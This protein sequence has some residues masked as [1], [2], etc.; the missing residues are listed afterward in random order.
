M[1]DARIYEAGLAGRSSRSPDPWIRA[2]LAYA[3]GRLRDPEANIYFPVLLRDEDPAVR[4]AAAFG[5]GVSGDARLVRLLVPVLSDLDSKTADAAA[6]SLG[7]LGGEEATRALLG[8]AGSSLASGPRVAA[9][10]A[11]WRGSSL[12]PA[13]VVPLLGP[14]AGREPADSNGRR[15]RWEAVYALARKPVPEAAPYLRAAL[16]SADVSLVATAAR[17]LGILQ[18]VDAADHLAGLAMGPDSSV[19]IQ[20]LGALE[21]IAAKSQ[22]PPAARAAARARVMDGRP[23]VRVAALRLLGR[24]PN[25][26]EV[27]LLLEGAIR[28][29][30]W[31]SQAALVSLV[32][33]FPAKGLKRCLEKAR[34]ESLDLKLG[35]AEA[36][37]LVPLAGR[38]G[39][40]ERLLADPLPRV[41]AAVLA[42]GDALSNELILK[43]LAD[44]DAA[45]RAAAAEAGAAARSKAESAP[46]SGAGVVAGAFAK[47]WDAAFDGLLRETEADYTVTAL[48]AAALLG[49]RGQDLLAR[50]VDASDA[51]VRERARKLLVEKYKASANSF[52][53]MP[54]RSVFGPRDYAQM[55]RD[56]NESTFAAGLLASRGVVSIDLLYEDA[57]MTVESFRRL[58]AKGLFDGITIHR[59]VPDFVVQAGDPRGD[60]TGGPGYAI[61]DEIN[62]VPYER[63]TVGMAL[64][65]PDTGGSQWFITLAPQPHLDGSYTVFGRVSAYIERVDFI[66]QNDRLENVTVEVSPRAKRP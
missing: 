40:A 5:A 6:E 59:V 29:E 37:P 54:V 63:G 20:A 10:R 61:R 50:Y 26:E 46:S 47:S 9:A 53:R 13:Y 19:V 58:A 43:G 49:K 16:S 32:R 12:T 2:K 14:L 66:E 36:L 44:G 24:F 56:A 7:K 15:L 17:G 3:L 4:R 31:A 33:A 25:D 48:E 27:R 65:G 51:V 28:E 1:E 38:S 30:G 22:L 11:L 64:S 60:G 41:R 45:V 21:K 18:V 57:P 35:A 39:L 52:R 34:G 8:A 62:P 23:G 55:S 42:A